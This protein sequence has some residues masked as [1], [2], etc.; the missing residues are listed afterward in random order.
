ML[1]SLFL[2]GTSFHPKLP[3]FVESS[4]SMDSYLNR[5]EKFGIAQKLDKEDYATFLSTLLT[6]K[7]LDVYSRLPVEHTNDYEYL[8]AALLSQ[9]QLT[10][11]DFRMK[12]FSVRQSQSET[13]PQFIANLDQYLSRWIDL[14]KTDHTFAALRE[15]ILGQ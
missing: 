15:L 6:G 14:T 12:F 5:F 7:A 8:K 11:D 13:A 9:Y 1:T 2:G 4:D 3:C 10:G